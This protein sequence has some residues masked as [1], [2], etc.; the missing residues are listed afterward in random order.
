MTYP[1]LDDDQALL[2]HD[3]GH[4]VADARL[5]ADF[6]TITI[7][8]N[9]AVAKGYHYGDEGTGWEPKGM[10]TT[11]ETL[12]AG[13]AFSLV[14]ETP[15]VSVAELLRGALFATKI[16][17]DGRGCH[18]W[19]RLVELVGHNP[20]T[21]KEVFQYS[22]FYT[23]VAI[24]H[25]DRILA[26]TKAML[27]EFKTGKMYVTQGVDL[28]DR[29]LSDPVPAVVAGLVPTCIQ[30]PKRADELADMLVNS[31]PEVAA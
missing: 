2:G 24:R 7:E 4:T 19:D 9:T 1:Y 10:D 27:P 13:P 8:E 31:T 16:L 12:V 5:G 18:D 28:R 22:I 14:L 20:I 3:T 23:C 29:Y 25:R 21:N 30:S 26:D 6:T 11:I 15:D 17:K